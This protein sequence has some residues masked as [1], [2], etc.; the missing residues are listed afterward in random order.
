M[1][2][3]TINKVFIISENRLRLQNRSHLLAMLSF[4]YVF[5]LSALSC[6]LLYDKEGCAVCVTHYADRQCGWCSTSNTCLPYSENDKCPNHFYY[7]PKANCSSENPEP[8]TPTPAPTPSPTPLPH[9]CEMYTSEGCNVCT[10]HYAD[11]NCGWCAETGKCEYSNTSV[12]N[13]Q[14]FYYGD[15]AKCGKPIPTPTPTPWPRYEA[16]ATFCYS[17]TDSWCSKCVSTNKDMKCVW[18]HETRE[19]V[20]GDSYGPFFGTCKGKFSFE[21]DNQCKGIASKNTIYTVRIVV[22]IIITA[23]TVF[24]ILGC[25]KA[26]KTPSEPVGYDNIH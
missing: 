19:C 3:R 16:N 14:S 8:Y 23:I 25:Y 26:I 11:R 5:G 4:F 21:D 18:C 17:L 22:G 12:C 24:S 7:G 10:G 15:N 6:Q 9:Q 20:M 13:K 2:P 1:N